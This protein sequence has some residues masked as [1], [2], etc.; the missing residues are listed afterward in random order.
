MNGYNSVD[1]NSRELLQDGAA[2]WVKTAFY[3][4]S[5]VVNRPPAL[6]RRLASKFCCGNK[7]EELDVED[8]LLGKKRVLL[9]IV[10]FS[11]PPLVFRTKIRT[12]RVCCSLLASFFLVMFL[13]I[14]LG[15]SLFGTNGE[16]QQNTRSDRFKFQ[17]V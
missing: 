2:Y 5:W 7:K 14:L 6:V 12:D 4:C 1:N 9:H 15:V 8:G 17:E 3:P 10:Q 16:G 13:C 11:H